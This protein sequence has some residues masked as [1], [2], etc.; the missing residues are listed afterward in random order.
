MGRPAA[1][2]ILGVRERRPLVRANSRAARRKVTRARK[3]TEKPWALASRGANINGTMFPALGETLLDVHNRLVVSLLP[4]ARE[5]A[6]AAWETQKIK[7]RR[8]SGG[9]RYSFFER[10]A[11]W[12]D[13]AMASLVRTAFMR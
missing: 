13:S 11:D 1:A 5:E 6:V 9:M 2:N 7:R 10:D 8:F 3:V 4:Q 12:H